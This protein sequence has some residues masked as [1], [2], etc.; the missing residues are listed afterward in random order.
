MR[1][2]EALHLYRDGKLGETE[3]L[4]FLRAYPTLELGDVRLDR[5]RALRKGFPEVVFGQGKTLDQL[6]RILTATGEETST[7][8]ITRL[9]EST[10]VDLEK[11]FPRLRYHEAA[12]CAYL[13]DIPEI[14]P[15]PPSPGQPFLLALGAGT[16]DAPVVEEAALTARLMGCVVEVLHDLGVAGLHRL[17]EKTERLQAAA[18]VVVAAGMD[19][20]LPGVVTGLVKAPVIA[21]PT[22]VGYGASFQGLAALLSMLNSCAPGLT[23]VNIDNGFGAGYA[24]AQILWMNRPKTPPTA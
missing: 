7:L 12:R 1:L 20:A 19:A 22:S 15:L 10:F 24:A 3:M 21:V 5:H 6:R 23:V 16:T 9:A 17:L 14:V 13:S 18:V 2:E 11:E 8:L 4:E